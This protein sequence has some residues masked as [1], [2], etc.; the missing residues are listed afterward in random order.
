MKNTTAFK[1]APNVITVNH[2]EEQLQ[3]VN[4]SSRMLPVTS[5][6]TARTDTWLRIQM[7]H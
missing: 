2:L 5:S 3:L 7:A 4:W 1:R 6:L